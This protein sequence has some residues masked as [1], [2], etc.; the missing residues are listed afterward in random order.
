MTKAD[1]YMYQI[2]QKIFA[3]GYKDK[4][5]RPRYPDGTPAHTFSINHN[6]P[7]VQQCLD[8]F[9]DGER[10]RILRMLDAISVHI[11]FDDILIDSV[12]TISKN[13]LNEE[14]STN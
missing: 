4:H 5:P 12:Y 14:A 9:E 6:S 11:P 2:I 8:S 3:E 7:F 13:F 10:A 1:R